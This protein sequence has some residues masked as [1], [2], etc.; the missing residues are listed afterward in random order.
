M[1]LIESDPDIYLDE[2]VDIITDVF[3]IH[4]ATV[5]NSENVIPPGT[6]S[7]RLFFLRNRSAPYVSETAVISAQLF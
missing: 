1:E 5:I 4:H 3:G 2:M 6:T 7:R